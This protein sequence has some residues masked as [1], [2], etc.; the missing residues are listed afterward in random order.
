MVQLKLDKIVKE[1]NH[2][3]D[4]GYQYVFW[5]DPDGEFADDVTEDNQYLKDNLAAELQPVGA[6]DQFK[7]KRKLLDKK[8]QDRSFLVYVKAKRPQLQFDYLA[9]M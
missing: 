5:Y 8:N 7:I 4:Q 9:D 3:F 1:I 6:K 2:Y